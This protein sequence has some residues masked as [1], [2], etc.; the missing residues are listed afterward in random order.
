MSVRLNSRSSRSPDAL[1]AAR[2]RLRELPVERALPI[3]VAGARALACRRAGS[4]SSAGRSATSI[5]WP[6][7]ITV[8][9]WQ[10]F[11]SCRTLPGNEKAVS[12]L[13]RVVGQHLRLDGEL[14]RALREE[15]PGERRR[16]RR[17]RSR[18]GGRRNAHDVEA[19]E[20]VLAEQAQPHALLEILV[21]RRDDAD[22]RLLR[23]VAA[24]AVVLAVGEHAQQAHLQI[25]RHV[26]DLVQ[27]QRAALGLLEAPAARR[28]ARR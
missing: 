4:R 8:I 12:S 23:R 19:M 28:S 22:I 13:Q 21:R 18:S 16:C 17:C 5:R 2:E 20:Q 9:Q 6:G 14:A 15:M 10:M 3:D 11:S 7:A 24:D 27:E 25:G 1:L 26:A